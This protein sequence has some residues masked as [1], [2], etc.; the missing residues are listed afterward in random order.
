MKMSKLLSCL[1]VGSLFIMSCGKPH[2]PESINS[3]MGGYKKVSSFVTAGNAQDVVFKDQKVFIAE[4]EVGLMIV[5][6]SNPASPQK[7][8]IVSEGARGYSTRV[9]IKDSVVYLAAGSFGVTAINVA[10]PY[11]PSVAVNNVGAKPARNIHIMDDYMVVAISELGVV[12]ADLS[13]P[14]Y[15]DIRG[16]ISTTPGY[17]MG[18]TS[19]S[20]KSKLLVATGE[21]GLV[22]Y[23]ISVFEEGY[24]EYPMIGS[25]YTPG[26]AESVAVSENNKIAFMAC[27]NEGLQIL[28]FSNPEK[29]KV[30]GSF[31]HSGYAKALIYKNNRVYI[32]A[33]KGGLQIVDVNDVTKPVLIGRVGTE[34]AFGLDVSGDYIYIAD[35]IAGLIIVKAGA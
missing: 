35:E 17:A 33:R 6:V 19:T 34:G 30:V 16:D 25:F 11:N 20:D 23:D 28:D 8:S 29:I 22:I 9:Q 31:Y 2:D 27:G 1:L 15:P 26:Y 21:Y 13:N 18:V 24:G 3:D 32:A 10:D 7:V 5:D 12:F 14:A 4:G